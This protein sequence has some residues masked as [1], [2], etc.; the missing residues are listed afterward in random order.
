[1]DGLVLHLGGANEQ[2]G[3]HEKMFCGGG[4]ARYAKLD[5]DYM[6]NEHMY[7]QQIL[8]EPSIIV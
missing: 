2:F 8:G 6:Y 5:P 7:P 3:T 1:M 4:G